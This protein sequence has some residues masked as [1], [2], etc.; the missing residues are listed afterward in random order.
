[1]FNKEYCFFSPLFFKSANPE[2]EEIGSRSEG[3]D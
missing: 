1:M 3:F 2:Q